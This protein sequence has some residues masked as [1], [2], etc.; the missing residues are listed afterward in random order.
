MTS[1]PLSLLR[2]PVW[3]AYGLSWW[4]W[5]LQQ[6]AKMAKEKVESIS[7]S[8]EVRVGRVTCF[9]QWDISKYEISKYL[10]SVCTWGLTSHCA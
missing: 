10:R 4:T 2:L 6:V 9:G 1:I 8:L 5:V 7:P 3:P